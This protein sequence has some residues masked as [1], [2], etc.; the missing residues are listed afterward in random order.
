[1]NAYL[2]YE[3]FSK[4]KNEINWFY[5]KP[6]QEIW[7]KHSRD[8]L[9]TLTK[10]PSWRIDKIYAINDDKAEIRKA[11]IDGKQ[12][13]VAVSNEYRPASNIDIRTLPAEILRIKPSEQNFTIGE[14]IVMNKPNSTP[15]LCKQEWMDKLDIDSYS[16]FI[17][18]IPADDDLVWVWNDCDEKY[19]VMKHGE[20]QLIY[21][22]IAP[23]I[24]RLP[25]TS[26]NIMQE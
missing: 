18:W 16:L 14:Y 10:S 23:F 5:S 24:G 19:M 9:W 20:I 17:K 13:E 21:D 6:D 1:M 15:F 3:Q 8:N 4:H 7:C 12:V 11:F 25:K 22:N 26:A 2:Y